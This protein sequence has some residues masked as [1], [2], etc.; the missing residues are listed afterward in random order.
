MEVL[1]VGILIWGVLTLLGHGTWVLIRGIFRV[2]ASDPTKPPVSRP[3]ATAIPRNEPAGS[4]PDPQRD[5]AAFS[6]MVDA[7][8]STEQISGDQATQLKTKARE[9]VQQYAALPSKPIQPKPVELPAA[10]NTPVMSDLPVQAPPRWNEESSRPVS[11]ET[12]ARRGLAD[13][14]AGFLEQHN[15]RWG[16]LIA[17]M[18]IVLCSI[19]LVLSLWSTLTAAHRIVPA[20]VFMSAD[21]AIFAAGLYTMRRW[22]LRH[23]SRAVLIIATLLVPLCV[24]AGLAAAG[25]NANATSVSLTDPVTLSV[26]VVATIGCGW[27]LWQASLA[28]VGRSGALALTSSVIASSL[29]LPLLPAAG[30]WLGSHA[31]WMILVP[32]L[33]TAIA[34]VMR[35]G[36][37][38][39]K[40]RRAWKNHWLHMGIVVGA[41]GSVVVYAAFFFRDAGEAI[42]LQIAIST[43]P[44]WV[45]ITMIEAMHCFGFRS[46][47]LLASSHRATQR[48]IATVLVFVAIGATAAILPA[49]F[50]SLSW[51]WTHAIAVSLSAVLFSVLLRRGDQVLLAMLPVAFVAMATSTV[52]MSG[53]DWA[54]VDLLRTVL[55]GEP[56]LFAVGM[57][58]IGIVLR[59]GLGLQNESTKLWTDL[60]EV[61]SIGILGLGT[62]WR[63]AAIVA[64]PFER[65]SD[66]AFDFLAVPAMSVWTLALHGAGLIGLLLS[67]YLARRD[68]ST[69]SRE[70]LRVGVGLVGMLFIAVVVA[71]QLTESVDERLIA[72]VSFA[73]TGFAVLYWQMRSRPLAIGAIGLVSVGSMVLLGTSWFPSVMDHVSPDRL[74]AGSMAAWWIVSALGLM[75]SRTSWHPI[76]S[77]VLFALTAAMVTP[78]LRWTSPIVWF[79]A[80]ALGAIVWIGLNEISRR[81]FT[82]GWK[83]SAVGVVDSYPNEAIDLSVAWIRIVGVICAAMVLVGIVTQATWT[84]SW[85]LPLGGVMTLAALIT[86]AIGSTR[87]YRWPLPFLLPIMSGHLACFAAM[88]GW[89]SRDEIMTVV[90][91]CG[92]LGCLGSSIFVWWRRSTAHSWHVVG[93]SLFLTGSAIG[94]SEPT[95]LFAFIPGGWSASN[96]YVLLAVSGLMF[97]AVALMRFTS[98]ML[99][100]GLGWLVILAGAYLIG[101]ELVG[102]RFHA[103]SLTGIM[104]WLC[105]CVVLWRSDRLRLN[106]VSTGDLA[107]PDRPS[108]FG[109][110]ADTE[111]SALMLPMLGLTGWTVLMESGGRWI[112]SWDNSVTQAVLQCGVALLA[113][114][115]AWMCRDLR[116]GVTEDTESRSRWLYCVWLIVGSLA[117]GCGLAATVFSTD[118]GTPWVVLS[119]SA[120]S[121]LVAAVWCLPRRG[122]GAIESAIERVTI[123]CTLL[124]TFIAIGIATTSPGVE[125]NLTGIW[126]R[127]SVL[128]I[129]ILSWGMFSLSEQTQP[130]DGPIAQ[131]RRHRCVG[132]GLWAI[133]LIAT[134]GSGSLLRDD[135]INQGLPVLIATMRLVIASVVAISLLLLVIPKLLKGPFVDRWQLA[136][137][138]G[139]KIAGGTFIGSLTMMLVLEWTLRERDLGIEGLPM[140]VV[141]VVMLILGFFAVMAGTLAVLSG[142]V[143]GNDRKPNWLRLSDRQRTALVYGAQIVAGLT[144]L[145]FYLCRGSSAYLG[146]REVWPYVVMGIAFAS[147]GMAQ[148][149]LRRQDNVLFDAMKRTAMFLPLIPVVGFWLS[150]AYAMV[151]HELEWSWTFY[152]GATSYQAIL[153]VGAIYYGIMSM[154]WKN[155]FPRIATV[156]LA[157]AGLWVMLTQ[158]PGWGFLSHPQAWLIPPAACVLLI[159]H[160]Q[161]DSLEPKLG[162]AIR[163]GATLMIYLSS[164]ADILFSEI[165]TSLWG[166]M[167]LIGLSLVGMVAGVAMRVKPFLYLGT[168]FTFLGIMSMVWHAGQAIDAVW[169]WW[170]FG[171]TTGLILLSVLAGIEK[172]KDQLRKWSDQLAGWS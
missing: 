53:Q 163:Y 123:G 166:P 31:G 107:V 30:R 18:L 39:L 122:H 47:A 55:S 114:A 102:Y 100:R 52:W 72:M 138:R 34:L 104:A 41:L 27:L 11:A 40:G 45:A 17:G 14:L 125:S 65:V 111:A 56:M 156:V 153:I 108:T 169:P 128:G 28:L 106:G 6:R 81:F 37:T 170:V 5:L 25:A 159:A 83:Q 61:F 167:I 50:G 172:H 58:L 70:R 16:E 64:A 152:R 7:L 15:I 91:V 110:R 96:A 42:W 148:W 134:L 49:S 143:F 118:W 155:G 121:A 94:L 59:W 140:P 165:G 4:A 13:V 46:Q 9:F 151:W 133:A 21:A 36:S 74:I 88:F 85:S 158:T 73:A 26:I 10:A 136:L 38:T 161:R 119:L 92:W 93:Q 20:V 146:L 141:I 145:H 127:L 67:G 98:G 82:K 29:S 164:T 54:E 144:W 22:K 120:S 130:T 2:L 51:L 66:I 78:A 113:G 149:A 168:I 115:S 97:A 103:T 150:G 116:G 35:R 44:I 1:F 142:P 124:G 8:T 76:L 129:G 23:T 12:A 132:I 86:F 80:S 171:I 160:L 131:R 33:I 32:T 63:S 135:S 95:R 19:G 139:G 3:V 87:D 154:L 24:L 117:I 112:S 99:S 101:F 79:Q 68:E 109:S 137:R 57:L 84:I 126:T 48:F 89:I 105:G 157:N 77:A 69:A 60:W 43:V 71:T 75:R 147:V 90:V 62:L 162:S